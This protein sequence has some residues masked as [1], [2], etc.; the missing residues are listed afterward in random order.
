[1]GQGWSAPPPPRGGGDRAGPPPPGCLGRGSGTAR[2]EDL[3]NK[4]ISSTERGLPACEDKDVCAGGILSYALAAKRPG[5]REELW[6]QS[7]RESRAAKKGQ[8]EE[9]AKMFTERKSQ[10]KK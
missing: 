5:Q 6:R 9:N 2:R 10:W 1:M 7:L 3:R 8:R 4:G